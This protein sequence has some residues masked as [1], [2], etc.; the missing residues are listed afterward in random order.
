MEAPLTAAEEGHVPNPYTSFDAVNGPIVLAGAAE[1]T[2]DMYI[3]HALEVANLPGAPIA[4]FL[5][6]ELVDFPGPQIAI[7]QD[8][9]PQRLRQ[10]SQRQS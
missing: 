7:T 9:G 4:R 2:A 3:S 5:R 8:H 6:H 1:W 10:A